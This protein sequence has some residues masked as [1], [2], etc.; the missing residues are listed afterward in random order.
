MVA[1][2]T[3]LPTATAAE[4][5]VPEYAASQGTKAG[6]LSVPSVPPEDELPGVT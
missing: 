2:A 6:S 1:V 5:L 3:G 4:A